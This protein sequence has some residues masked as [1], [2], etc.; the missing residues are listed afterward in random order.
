MGYVRSDLAKVGTKL[1]AML[2]G[3][4]RPCEVAALPFVKHNYKKD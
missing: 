2:R 1:N 4:P 3:T